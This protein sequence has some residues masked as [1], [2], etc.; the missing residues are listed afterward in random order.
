MEPPITWEKLNAFVKSANENRRIEFR[1][2]VLN[3]LASPEYVVAELQREI[4]ESINKRDG[5]LCFRITA[6]VF[7]YVYRKFGDPKAVQKEIWELLKDYLKNFPTTNQLLETVDNGIDKTPVSCRLILC[8]NLIQP[9]S[10][11]TNSRPQPTS[12]RGDAQ[13]P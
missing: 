10:G 8:F 7:P 12:A 4:T 9:A 5:R 13:S 2:C 3:G 1:E 6:G 11:Q